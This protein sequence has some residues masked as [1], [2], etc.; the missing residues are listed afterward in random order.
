MSVVTILC[1]FLVTENVQCVLK[2]FL[3]NSI[4]R[5]NCNPIFRYSIITEMTFS[6]IAASVATSRLTED[7][8]DDKFLSTVCITSNVG[9]VCSGIILNDYWLLTTAH[10]IVKF[11][12]GDLRISY[13]SSNHHKLCDVDI[14]EIHPKYQQN[15]LTNNVSL[16][17][18]KFKFDQTQVQAAKLPTVDSAED[19]SAYA[20]GWEKVKRMV[21]LKFHNFHSRSLYSKE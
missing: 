19:E 21:S 2:I 12:K 1:F 5:P 14:I 10:C 3:K 16:I 9:H 17:K 8:Y 18:V 7:T 20:I 11:C 4:N 15:R 13:G 6:A